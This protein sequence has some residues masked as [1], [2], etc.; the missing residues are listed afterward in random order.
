MHWCYPCDNNITGCFSVGCSLQELTSS[1]CRF[2]QFSVTSF[3]EYHITIEISTC[4]VRWAVKWVVRG[5]RSS[6]SLPHC[7]LCSL[8]RL[9]LSFR[10]NLPSFRVPIILYTWR[11]SARRHLCNNEPLIACEKWEQLVASLAQIWLSPSAPQCSSF[12]ARWLSNPA[13]VNGLQKRPLLVRRPITAHPA[14]ENWTPKNT[15]TK[16]EII[17][18]E[19]S[20]KAQ[21]REVILSVYNYE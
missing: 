2:V 17:L 7:S 14:R 20:K 1:D 11:T 8:V 13:F 3:T 9:S 19:Q 16:N 10:N 21:S 5:P 12:G 4:C 15:H 18:S 6:N